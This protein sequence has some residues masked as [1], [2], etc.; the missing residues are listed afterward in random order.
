MS[1]KLHFVRSL[2]PKSRVKS[3][4][5]TSPAASTTASSSTAATSQHIAN[6]EKKSQL[7]TQPLS[8]EE[9][10]Q[11]IHASANVIN[12]D[13]DVSKKSD[14]IN[15][16]DDEDE[17]DA[18][19]EASTPTQEENGKN[20]RTQNVSAD[21]INMSDTDSETDTDS[22]SS[23]SDNDS[24]NE[25]NS[26][27]VN[28]VLEDKISNKVTDAPSVD[29]ADTVEDN[30]KKGPGRPRKN[31]KKK[32]MKHDGVILQP[33]NAENYMEL[34][35]DK[36]LMIKKISQFFK[37][38]AT[39]N[40]HIIFREREIILYGM[41][42]LK[43]S[44][45]RVRIDANKMIKY[46]VQDEF[47][48]GIAAKHLEE[49]LNM[50]DRDYSCVVILSTKAMYLNRLK[51]VFRNEIQIEECH[52]IDLISQYDKLPNDLDFTNEEY[53]IKFNLPGKYFRKMINDIRNLTDVLNIC[54][55]DRKEPMYFAYTKTNRK[56]RSRHTVKNSDKIGL[57]SK[58]EK[59][60]L[61]KVSFK[62]ENIKPISSAHLAE[63]VTLMVDE[64]KRLMY[65]AYLEDNAIEIKVL[66][67]T[68]NTQSK[69]KK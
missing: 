30:K 37:I 54:Q 24:V 63:Q 7:L 50:V 48:I 9:I 27:L 40:I 59:N 41:D 69:D 38:M 18:D 26:T 15:M 65:K 55:D 22:E 36:P 16:L 64:K 11:A 57:V 28:L 67:E 20:L 10:H 12:I 35:Y 25:K 32:P 19:S 21:V 66:T 5:S 47:G 4:A 3:F 8:K 17:S 42:H 52:E 33:V 58:L 49:L 60:C 61:F 34:V 13:E 2:A 6:L 46:Y 45:V 14:T 44:S 23:E 31:P 39:E 29:L 56:I 62:L 43:Q 53:C 1:T 68:I 51:I